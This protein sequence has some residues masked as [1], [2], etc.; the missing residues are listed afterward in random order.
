MA[1]TIPKYRAKL[2]LGRAFQ[3]EDPLGSIGKIALR[4]GDGLRSSDPDD[5][6]SSIPNSSDLHFVR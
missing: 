2:A 1:D 5:L 3:R 4:S 6:Y